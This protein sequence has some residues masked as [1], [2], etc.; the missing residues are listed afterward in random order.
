MARRTL[1]A[2]LTFGAAIIVAC[3]PAD[4]E[5]SGLAGTFTI[6]SPTEPTSA[7]VCE[8]PEKLEAVDPATLPSCCDGAHCLAK[9]KVP[10]KV[11]RS[12]A[13][14][15]GGYC[16]PDAF[17]RSGGAA[18]ATCTAFGK[19]GACASKCIPEVAK[20]V[21]RLLQDTC[22]AGDLCAP[23][24]NPLT[25]TVT[26]ICELGKPSTGGCNDAPAA[27]GPP[28]KCPHEGPPVIDPMTLPSCGEGAGAHCLDA[29]L[30]APAMAGKL[31]KCPTG[32]CVPDTFIASGGQF[33]PATCA[34]LGGGEGR[35]MS[36]V[37]P[38][39]GAQRDRLPRSTC[40]GR[41][42][43]APCFSPVDGSDTGACRISC[44]PGPKKPPYL[45]PSCCTLAGTPR[46]RCVPSATIDAKERE[47]LEA[48]VCTSSADLCV[49]GENLDDKFVPQACSAFSV[50]YLGNYAGVCL[51]NCLHFSG[52]SALAVAKGSC[53]DLH[54]CVP[55]KSPTG[56]PTGAPGCTP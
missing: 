49:P 30:V 56:T 21:D 15:P 5:G 19:P 25:N 12:L 28:P 36:E 10:G 39:I 37:L 48:D 8:G 20:N 34:S 24:I 51:S 7:G 45:F 1:I 38:D 27:A 26:G 22:G 18:P 29:K 42:L 47:N 32:L 11:R 9:E 31:A 6:A 40:G 17:L 3:E 35:C 23:C 41:E 52:L 50:A 2:V 4:I 44:D 43:C 46:G 33:I 13:E 54:Q 53:D 14:C 16:V 55:C